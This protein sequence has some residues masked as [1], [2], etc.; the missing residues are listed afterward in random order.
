[1]E[2]N[3]RIVWRPLP[4]FLSGIRNGETVRQRGVT[5][6]TPDFPRV[7]VPCPRPTTSWRPKE[8][9]SVRRLTATHIPPPRTPNWPRGGGAL[10]RL[11]RCRRRRGRCVRARRR[12]MHST[13]TKDGPTEPRHF[14]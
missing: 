2:L 13:A 14:K 8:N 9:V 6:R 11:R 12:R 1:M 3:I 5:V 4:G 10:Q 7:T